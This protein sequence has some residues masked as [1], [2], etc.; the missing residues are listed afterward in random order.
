MRTKIA[1]GLVTALVATGAW[2]TGL[3]RLGAV[4]LPNLA[5]AARVAAAGGFAYVLG[6]TNAGPVLVVV[7]ATDPAAPREVARLPGVS[8]TSITMAGSTVYAFGNALTVVDVSIPTAPVV[9]GSVTVTSSSSFSG[10]QVSAG[11]AYGANSAGLHVIDARNPAAPVEVATL[12]IPSAAGVAIADP[13]STVCAAETYAYVT[14]LDGSLTIANVTVPSSP[15]FVSNVALGYGE[16]WGVATSGH[17]VYAT[18]FPRSTDPET[19]G[20]PVPGRLHVLDAS[21]PGAPTVVATRQQSKAC[22]EIALANGYAYLVEES[23]DMNATY[24]DTSVVDV[25]TP[26]APVEVRRWRTSRA[27]DLAVA[28]GYV[29]V[30][31]NGYPASLVVYQGL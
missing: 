20:D 23:V 27:W 6:A 15:R 3:V 4:S 24:D 28:G 11:Y 25:R 5:D 14:S 26:T 12:S 31:E 8:G 21:N 2:G 16:A 13:G 10:I 17:Y 22:H 9:V 30:P 7:D 29:Y 18:T 19:A 1:A